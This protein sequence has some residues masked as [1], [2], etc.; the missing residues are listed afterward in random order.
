MFD[1]HR[2]TQAEVSSSPVLPKA[3]KEGV[4]AQRKDELNYTSRLALLCFSKE[5]PLK[6]ENSS[7]L[8]RKLGL[9]AS[10]ALVIGTVIGTGVF[11]KTAVMAQQTGS[12]TGV[13]LAWVV[14]GALS[15][16]GALTY[17]ELG[18]LFPQAGG[19]YVYLR[20]GYG[21]LLGFLYGW[22]RFWIGSP[23]SIAAYAVGAATFLGGIFPYQNPFSLSLVAVGI[24][25]LFTGLN[26]FSVAFG[27][28][29]QAVMTAVKLFMII[30]LSFFILIGAKTGSW[31]H[32][33]SDSSMTG[34]QGWSAFGSA[35]LAALWAFD[36]WNNLPMA[37]GEIKDPHR[38]IPR[39]LGFGMIIV[40]LMYGLANVSYFYAL[41]FSQV[42]QSHSSL[43]QQAL[44]VA[45]NAAQSVFGPSAIGILSIAF[46]FSAIGALNGSILTSA[47]VPYAMSQDGLFFKALGKISP[48]THVPVVAILVQGVW[49]S[50]LALSGSFDQLTDYVVFASW[51]F[52][53]LVTSS[54]FLF[55]VRRPELVRSYKAPGYPWLP[56]IFL[57]CSLL[58]LGNTLFTATKESLIGLSFILVGIPAYG[59]FKRFG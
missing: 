6:L 50:V 46:V 52:Y 14:A 5:K 1:S 10:T 39:A 13:L 33:Q 48:R 56:G 3:T 57:L 53:A 54:L 24:I 18:S 41:P 42:V 27:G 28:G 7:K 44:P 51:I 16:A 35:V 19:E 11:L 20:E 22:M 17:G 30:G 31:S 45:T 32:L 47:R 26:C 25:A 59:L 58:L 4:D 55:R 37:A 49:A 40:L 23:G 15:L 34:W 21:S 12:P 9:K 38:V 36:G 2:N 8:L 29:L 43:Y